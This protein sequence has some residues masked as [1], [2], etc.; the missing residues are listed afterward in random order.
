MQKQVREKT[1]AGDK[2]SRMCFMEKAKDANL[3]RE[4]VRKD[5]E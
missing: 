1:H 3:G 2:R 4:S 5:D